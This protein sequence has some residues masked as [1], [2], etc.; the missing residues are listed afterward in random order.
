MKGNKDSRR[1]CFSLLS[2]LK[3]F[4]PPTS[5]PVLEGLRGLYGSCP[6]C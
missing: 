6:H 2:D 5:V 4:I 1:Y 3:Q